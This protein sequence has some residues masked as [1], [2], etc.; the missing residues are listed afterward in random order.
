MDAFTRL[1]SVAAPLPLANVDTDQ[2]IPAA[3]L[4]TLERAGLAKGLFYALRHDEDGSAKDFVLDRPAYAGAQILIA[5]KNFGC[6]S[7]REHAPW[8]LLDA[9]IRCIISPSFADIFQNNCFKNG[10]LAITV[11]ED[12]HARLLEGAERGGDPGSGAGIDAGIGATLTVD[13]AKQTIEGP[14]GDLT[15][16][17]IDPFRKQCLLGGLDDISLTLEKIAEIEAF[18]AQQQTREPWLY[19]SRS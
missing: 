9:G 18:E 14:D 16:F 3:Y 12:V 11:P 10:I 8:A 5:G 4:K 15:H 6:G 17:A 1:T 19:P 7:S 2:I 13:L